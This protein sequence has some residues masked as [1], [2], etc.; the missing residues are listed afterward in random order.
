METPAG[1]EAVTLDVD[2]TLY[3]L[4]RMAW[5]TWWTM[6][7]VA[8]LFRDL[9]RVRE[10]MRGADPVEDFRREQAIRLAAIRGISREDAARQV[11][12]LI[13]RWT[14][15]FVRL[16]PYPGM[17]DALL[18]LHQRGVRLGI[19]S[20]Y[21]ASGKLAG[22]GLEHL[23]FRTITVAEEVGALKP[24][25]AAF[26]RAVEWLDASPGRV[27]HVGDREDCDVAGARGAGMRTAR[28]QPGRKRVASRADVV[29]SRWSR[30]VPALES[31][32]L[33]SS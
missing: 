22:L 27:L 14:R 10:Q 30:F 17:R 6:L 19:V 29:F 11:E 5:R 25:P 4:R 7:P 21:P 1:I 24:H 26:L 23:P 18:Q 2:G 28:F 20:D 12:A 3:S 8:D 9:Q 15:L 31:A 13:L 32:G 16:R 33:L